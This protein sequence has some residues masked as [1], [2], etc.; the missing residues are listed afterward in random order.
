M[1]MVLHLYAQRHDDGNKRELFVIIEGEKVIVKR[2]SYGSE[3]LPEWVRKRK[4][5]MIPLQVTV[6]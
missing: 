4:Y 6:G 3:L 1:I 2:I 5:V